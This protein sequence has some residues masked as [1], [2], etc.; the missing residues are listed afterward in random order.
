MAGGAVIA[1]ASGTFPKVTPA[2]V[3]AW[4]ERGEAFLFVDARPQALFDLKHARGAINIPAFSMGSRPLPRGAKVVLYDGGAGSAEAVQAA[5]ALQAK[6]HPEFYLLE[7]GLTAWEAQ[8]LPIVAPPGE[9]ATLFVEPVAA[10]DLLRLI[11]ENE[12]VKILDLRA[13]D[14]YRMSHVPRAI[15]AATDESISRAVAGSS[16][17]DL[18]VL[19]DDGSGDAR[20]KGE[21]LRRRGFLAVKYLHGGMLAWYEKN[22]RVE[23]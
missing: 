19:Y 8:S 4:Q 14:V 16:P 5:L 18:I 9:S 7:G 15:S 21:A 2:E 6:G 13:A 1:R 23:R 11:D 20:Q 10:E 12:K 17:A 22:L 3:A